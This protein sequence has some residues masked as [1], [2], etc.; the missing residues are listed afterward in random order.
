MSKEKVFIGEK[1]E[2]TKAE[3]LMAVSL[4]FVF[5]FSF[6]F[7]S[8]Q[9]PFLQTSTLYSGYVIEIPQINPLKQNQD[10]T[11]NFHVFNI[12]NGYP[13]DNST[14]SCSIHL[15]NSSGGDLFEG[16]VPHANTD[17]VNEWKIT[18]SGGN[19]SNIG[20]HGYIVQCN[21]SVS[22]LGGFSNV[23]IEVTPN[24]FLNNFGYYI[25]ILLLS[26]GVML[27]GFYIEDHWIVMFGSLGLYFLGIYTLFF[28]ING[29]LDKTYTWGFSILILGL[30]MYFSI[31]A[32]YEAFQD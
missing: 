21:D 29:M 14:T 5:L 26:F 18:L 7:I 17:V 15:Y 30:A 11:A 8:A 28:G 4:L 24:G 1:K 12:S 3:S 25:I 10:F 2:K 32:G 13:I 31:R 23:G 22:K 6:S 27:I 16:N 9:P 19:F 20:N